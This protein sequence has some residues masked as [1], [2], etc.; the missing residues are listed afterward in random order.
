MSQDSLTAA[1]ILGRDLRW[2][3]ACEVAGSSMPLDSGW[4]AT[5]NPAG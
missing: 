2:H 5:E 3:S 4:P 1:K